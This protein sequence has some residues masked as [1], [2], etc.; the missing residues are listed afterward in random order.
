M[1]DQNMD[2]AQVMVPPPLVFL[3]YLI[4]ALILNWIV[5]FP[6][7]WTFVLR[8]VGGFAIIGGILFVGSAFLQMRKANTPVDPR[9]P[10]TAFVTTGPYRFTRNPI[11]LGFFLIYLGFTLLAGTLWGLIA[12]PFLI[13]T[14]TN[15]VIRAEE[16]YLDEKFGEQYKQY[17]SRVRPWI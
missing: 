4:G 13:W 5:P 3:G 6:A 12:S 9:E 15:A 10:V 8:I 17:R 14:I 1:T 7:P 11:Y 2:H 16:I